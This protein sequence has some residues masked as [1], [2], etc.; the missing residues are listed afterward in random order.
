MVMLV[1][2]LPFSW[3]DISRL[4]NHFPAAAYPQSLSQT[5]LSILPTLFPFFFFPFINFLAVAILTLFTHVKPSSSLYPLPLS[6]TPMTI[7]PTFIFI[8][9]RIHE[10]SL[11]WNGYTSCSL[12]I[13][14]D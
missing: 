7:K 11:M 2:Y 4:G 10:V 6:L 8:P 3:L 9:L 13:G 14:L 1:T 12:S 5:L